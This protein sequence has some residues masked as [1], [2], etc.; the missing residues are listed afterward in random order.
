[1]GSSGSQP[2]ASHS[3]RRPAP[4]PQTTAH[5]L[6][7]AVCCSLSAA[8]RQLESL[9]VPLAVSTVDPFLYP[10][11]FQS[12]LSLSLSLSLTLFLAIHIISLFLSIHLL[13]VL[14]PLMHLILSDSD[15]V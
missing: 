15:C 6:P 14:I 10:L 11:F 8:N 4:P 3:T 2:P 13:Y 12:S 9:V 5:G 7:T 1:M